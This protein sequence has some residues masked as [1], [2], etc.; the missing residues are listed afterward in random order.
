MRWGKESKIPLTHLIQCLYVIMASWLLIKKSI[1]LINKLKTAVC[2]KSQNHGLFSDP[3][4]GNKVKGHKLNLI[5]Q[6]C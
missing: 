3:N 1:S 4:E 2:I 5:R 6:T